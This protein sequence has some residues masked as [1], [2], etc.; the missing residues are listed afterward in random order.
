MISVLT[1]KKKNEKQY[2]GYWDTPNQW[3]RESNW[4]RKRKFFKKKSFNKQR[5]EKYKKKYFQK[6]SPKSICSLEKPP[7]ASRK[8]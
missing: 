5:G 4:K 2:L 8:K 7:I 6:A 1:S 3:G